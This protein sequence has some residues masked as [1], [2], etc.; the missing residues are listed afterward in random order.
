MDED[1]ILFITTNKFLPLSKWPR[2][3]LQLSILWMKTFHG[4]IPWLP[5][6]NTNP[7]TS[8]HKNL[9]FRVEMLA[10]FFARTDPD[11]D[12]WP[13][14]AFCSGPKMLA[15]WLIGWMAG[16]QSMD[17]MDSLDSMDSNLLV[18]KVGFWMMW[19]NP[20]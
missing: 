3:D 10:S 1:L 7:N 15:G 9:P 18:Q 12:T 5:W 6:I 14:K 19:S 8:P 4:F 11:T 16:W 17:S 2:M 20:P 13:H